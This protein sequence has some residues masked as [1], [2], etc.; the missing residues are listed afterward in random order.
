MLPGAVR[1]GGTIGVVRDVYGVSNREPESATIAGIQIKLFATVS[2]TVS[3]N[4]RAARVLRVG[5]VSPRLNGER[6]VVGVRA[7]VDPLDTAHITVGRRE[8]PE[9]GGSVGIIGVV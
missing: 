8:I 7:E 3:H 6:C 4:A 9:S 1:A 5:S 2:V